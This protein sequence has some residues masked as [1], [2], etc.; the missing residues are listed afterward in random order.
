MTA[1]MKTAREVAK[2]ALDATNSATGCGEHDGKNW[3]E[4][5]SDCL[6]AN[7]AQALLQREREALTGVRNEIAAQWSRE[8]ELTND[9]GVEDYRR[10]SASDRMY[11]LREA[12]EAVDSRLRK[13]VAKESS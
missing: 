13:L 9:F 4:V 6:V 3:R 12:V 7:I 2:E 11:A 5:C 10:N 1:P 8:H